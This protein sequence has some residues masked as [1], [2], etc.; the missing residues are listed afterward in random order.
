MAGRHGRAGGRGRAAARDPELTAALV[1]GAAPS[2][3]LARILRRG[4]PRGDRGRGVTLAADPGPVAAPP[5]RGG[6][7]RRGPAR[8]GSRA[9]TVSASTP[10][11]GDGTGSPGSASGWRDGLRPIAWGSGDTAATVPRS[12]SSFSRSIPSRIRLEPEEAGPPDLAVELADDPRQLAER[13]AG[14]EEQPPTV[15]ADQHHPRLDQLRREQLVPPD[16]AGPDWDPEAPLPDRTRCRP[17]VSSVRSSVRAIGA[18]RTAR[19]TPGSQT[20]PGARR[21][22]RPSPTGAGP[23]RATPHPTTT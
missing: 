2:P 9:T 6:G 17:T 16:V 14:G 1:L 18:R 3:G 22:P 10:P 20:E 8:C 13:A 15:A 4:R 21:T 19:R 11:R 7:D 5:G 12:P 23:R